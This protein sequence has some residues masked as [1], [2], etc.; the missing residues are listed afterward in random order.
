MKNT[1]IVHWWLGSS[2]EN[3]LPWLKNEIQYKAD[4]V[5]IPNLPNTDI[6]V[7]EEQL[8]KI[9]EFI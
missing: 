4:E 9:I 5:F 7:I 2:E 6:P 8:I 1:L 3:W